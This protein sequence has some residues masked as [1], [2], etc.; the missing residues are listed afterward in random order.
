[1]PIQAVCGGGAKGRLSIVVLRREDVPRDLSLP[2]EVWVKESLKWAYGLLV[3]PECGGD[4]VMF[5]LVHVE[6]K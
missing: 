4:D 5:S 6:R 2:V 1:M 3:D